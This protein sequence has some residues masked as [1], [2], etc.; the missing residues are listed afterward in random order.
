M[1]TRATPALT[2]ALEYL[3]GLRRDSARTGQRLPTVVQ[4]AKK[5]GVSPRA[6]HHAVR[7]CAQAGILSVRHRAGTCWADPSVA[8]SVPSRPAGPQAH[9]PRASRLADEM[10]Q[11]VL[12]GTL[13]DPLPPAKVLRARYRTGHAVVRHARFR[14]FTS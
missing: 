9:A 11:A 13:P 5:A 14:Q 6:M 8:V 4:L 10:E 1:S 12:S 7:A 3:E 2:T